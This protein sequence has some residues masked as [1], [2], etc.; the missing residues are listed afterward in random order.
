LE[1][2]HWFTVEFGLIKKPE[3]MRVY[4]A[5]IISSLGEVQHA[6]SNDVEVIDFK[7]ERIVNQKYD[8]WHLQPVLFAIDSFEQLENGFKDWTKKQGLL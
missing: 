3:G 4:G 2:F 8:V 5:G 6:L 1:T 7:P